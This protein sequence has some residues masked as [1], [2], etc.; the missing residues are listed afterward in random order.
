MGWRGLRSICSGR[1]IVP[2]VQ[3]AESAKDAYDCYSASYDETN[4]QNNYEMWLGE[5]LL[6]ELERHG[7]RRGWALDVGCGTGRAFD[8]LLSR[9]W[10][11]VGCDLS[12][13]MLAEATYKFGPRI[14]LLNLDGRDLP[15]ICPSPGLPREQAFQLV[16]LL[17]DVVNYMTEDGDLERAFAGV[18]RNLSPKQGLVVFDI[19]TIALFRAAFASG[20]SKEMSARGLRWRGLSNEV[21]PGMVCRAQLSGP[22]IEPHEHRQRHWTVQQVTEALDASGL[23]CRAILGQKEQEGRILLS[24]RLDEERDHKIIFLAGRK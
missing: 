24:D 23:S 16:L 15:P 3:G 2:L 19:N 7:L 18:R 17:N 12:P 5:A 9:G 21:K 11:V 10:R 8:P 14:S 22:S 20:V 1:T 6:P 13:G 4:A